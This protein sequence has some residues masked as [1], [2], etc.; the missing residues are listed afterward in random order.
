[1]TTKPRFFL[2]VASILL[3]GVSVLAD[4]GWYAGLAVGSASERDTVSGVDIDA[5]ETA[6]KLF[7]GYK[8]LEMV[9]VELSLSHFGEFGERSGDLEVQENLYDAAAWARFEA[10]INRRMWL[11]GKLGVAYTEARIKVI[12]PTETT[13]EDRGDTALAWGIGV[14]GRVSDR[15]DLL[16]EFDGYETDVVGQLEMISVGFRYGF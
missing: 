8:F 12:S 1:M 15:I 11:T 9:G 5:R 10:P 3:G 13:R 2:V 14:G 4:E 7:A 16:V 6:G